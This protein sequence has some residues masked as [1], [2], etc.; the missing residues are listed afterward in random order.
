MSCVGSS[1]RR[2][3]HNVGFEEKENLPIHR[4]EGHQ[5]PLPDAILPRQQ[6]SFFKPRADNKLDEPR[7]GSLNL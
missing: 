4:E 1:N 5:A 2:A 3:V 6:P 7:N